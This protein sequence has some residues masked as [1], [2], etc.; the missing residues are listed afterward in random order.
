MSTGMNGEPECQANVFLP[1]TKGALIIL[2][3]SDLKS[4]LK[5]PVFYVTLC[6]CL[7]ALVGLILYLNNGKTQYNGN[8]L[9]MVIVYG[10]AAALVF[11]LLALITGN[12]WLHYGAALAMLFVCL[13]Y[14]FA[15][16]NF[17]S[18]WIIATDP[19][20]PQVLQQYFLRTGLMLISAIGAFAAAGIAK[21]RFYGNAKEAN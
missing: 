9:T 1:T 21:K 17:W 19:V 8:Q 4:R 13:E 11:F 6:S 15:E 18:N 12:R 10:L 14:I 7:L 20:A 2:M 3:L 16:I 5:K